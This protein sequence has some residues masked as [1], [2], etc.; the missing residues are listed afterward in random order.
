MKIKVVTLFGMDVGGIRRL[1]V[2]VTVNKKSGW[3]RIMEGA[4]TSYVI[5]RHYRKHNV[6]FV[7][8][9]AI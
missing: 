2:P 6:R 7:K 5:K 1:G 3:F 8:E 9:I 4:K